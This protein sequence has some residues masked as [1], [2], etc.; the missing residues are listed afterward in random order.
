M[1]TLATIVMLATLFSGCASVNTDFG[2]KRC[3]D[4]V[5]NEN[6]TIVQQMIDHKV[7]SQIELGFP[8]VW[9]YHP[10]IVES[11]VLEASYGNNYYGC[12]YY[13]K[14]VLLRESAQWHKHIQD[15]TLRR[16]ND[17]VKRMTNDRELL[18]LHNTFYGR[19]AKDVL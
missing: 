3:T 14:S 13:N 9:D 17:T 7:K 15:E 6:F 11:W 5:Y 12:N 16:Y 8:F 19:T 1:K 10:A 2:G 18:E 4:Y